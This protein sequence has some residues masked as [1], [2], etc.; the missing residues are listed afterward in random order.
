MKYNEEEYKNQ[1]K[2]LYGD[3]IE[4]VG[5]FKGL[6]QPILLKDKYGIVSCSKASLPLKYRPTIKAALNPTEY[7][8]NQL[9]E[10][11]PETAKQIT[12]ASEYKTMKQKMLFET[13]FGLV[14]VEPNSLMQGY[15]PNVRSAIDRKNYMYNQLKYLYGDKYDFEIQSTNRHE[16]KCI[17]ICP[18]H[19]RVE[20]DNDYIFSGCGCIECNTGWT[21]SNCLYIIKLI[22]ETESFYKLGI[23]YRKKNEELRRYRDYRKLG[24]K[25]EVIK[26]LD[27]ENFQICVDKEYKLKQLIKNNLYQPK[28]WD[29]ASS[30]E[31]F[32]KDLLDLVLENL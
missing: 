13:K 9:R 22:H 10:K 23:T 5:R 3:E 18:I 20:I 24:Y 11:Y 32:T 25:I 7:F 12:P 1:I 31:C 6:A 8:M 26:E 19:G 27:L 16:G 15:V 4:V 17:L 14:S 28:I 21:K 29:N 2:S 30:T